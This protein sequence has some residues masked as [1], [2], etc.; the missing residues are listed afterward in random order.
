MTCHP[1]GVKTII[2][3]IPVMA[4]L[5]SLPASA[6]D[7]GQWGNKVSPELRMWFDNVYNAEGFECCAIADGY[8]VE[9]QMR[10]DNHYW[11][12]FKGTWYKVP[13]EAVVRKQGNPTG[14]GVAWF[15]KIFGGRVVRCF[16]SVAEY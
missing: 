10:S 11:V 13:D 12:R 7:H 5:F 3:P 1:R 2:A 8:P 9:Y 4:L 15:T 16:V 14:G 6:E